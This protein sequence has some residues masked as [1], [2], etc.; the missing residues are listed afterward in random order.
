MTRGIGH[1][2]QGW[3][4]VHL[5]NFSLSYLLVGD[6]HAWLVCKFFFKKMA[7]DKF[8]VLLS[9]HLRPECMVKVTLK[10]IVLNFYSSN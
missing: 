10:R 4:L 1:R 8:F 3:A 2:R 6:M 9:L 5:N 7:D